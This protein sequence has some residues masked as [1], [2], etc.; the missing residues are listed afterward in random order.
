[1]AGFA[2][3]S[4]PGL[5]R[6]RAESAAMAGESTAG[7]SEGKTAVIMVWLPGGMS[8]IDSYDPKPDAT[9]EYRGPFNTI[10]TKVPGR[11]SCGG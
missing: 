4:L 11:C 8:H 1:L 10:P 5:L 2:S 9:A 6:L 7:A 3:L